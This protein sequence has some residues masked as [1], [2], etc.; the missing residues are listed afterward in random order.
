MDP[1]RLCIY[2]CV[3]VALDS[4]WYC[5]PFLCLRSCSCMVWSDVRKNYLSFLEALYI[6]KIFSWQWGN[7]LSVWI[8]LQCKEGIQGKQWDFSPSPSLSSQQVELSGRWKIYRYVKAL[9]QN[10]LAYTIL[11]FNCSKF[12]SSPGNQKAQL[13][14]YL[15]MEVLLSDKNNGNVYNNVHGDDNMK[16][17]KQVDMDLEG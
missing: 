13:L 15:P 10:F 7:F 3:V 14:L 9:S 6:K 1:G 8:W 4:S 17:I 5:I 2:S 16:S 11:M 12:C